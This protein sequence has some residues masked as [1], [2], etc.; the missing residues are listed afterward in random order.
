[1]SSDWIIGALAFVTIGLVMLLAIY[2]FGTFL[3]DP[4]IRGAAANVVSGGTAASTK[5]AE[6]APDGSYHD[7]PLK[8]QLD[9]SEASAHPDDLSGTLPGSHPISH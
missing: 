2:H 6:E 5:V 3:K 4:R 8:A 1:M 7:R 9:R